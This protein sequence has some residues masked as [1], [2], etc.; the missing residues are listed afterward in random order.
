M[1]CTINKK[2]AEHGRRKRSPIAIHHA[3]SSRLCLIF[4]KQRMVPKPRN[5]LSFRKIST[6][7]NLHIT[8]CFS[9]VCKNEKKV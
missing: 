7:T 2:R 8:F 4:P 5:T 1:F 9:T 6:Q 3:P